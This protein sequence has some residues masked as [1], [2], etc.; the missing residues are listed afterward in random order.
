MLAGTVCFLDDF[1]RTIL[2][3]DIE[4]FDGLSQGEFFEK[5]ITLNAS[6]V[7]VKGESNNHQTK[8]YEAVLYARRY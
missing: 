2:E 6:K 7:V 8:A 4:D 1:K 5:I 3:M